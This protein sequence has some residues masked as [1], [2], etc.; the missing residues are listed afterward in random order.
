VRWQHPNLGLV[1]PSDFIPIAEETGLVVPIG[2]WILKQA[3]LQSRRWNQEGLG[4]LSISVNISVH[5]FQKP[6]FVQTVQDALVSSGLA[7]GLLCLEI[8]ENV[9]MKNI[10]FVMKT[11]S[12]LKELGVH[13]AIDDFGTGYSSLSYLKQ[14]RVNTL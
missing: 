9:A 6:G 5:Q 13:I 10:A 1:S 4:S 3:C 2:T 14:F 7:P 8:T 11:I 12:R